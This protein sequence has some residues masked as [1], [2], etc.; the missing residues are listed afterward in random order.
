MGIFDQ[1]NRSLLWSSHGS[2]GLTAKGSNFSGSVGLTEPQ[3][4]LL[5]QLGAFGMDSGE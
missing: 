2:Q 1:E 3:K 5:R 4:T